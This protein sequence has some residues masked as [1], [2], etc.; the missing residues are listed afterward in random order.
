[1]HAWASG[2][3][4]PFFQLRELA[5]GELVHCTYSPKL[6][7][8][9][10]R[11]HESLERTVAHAYGRIRWDRT[12]NHILDMVVEDIDLTQPLTDMDFHRLFGSMPEFTGEMTTAEYIDWIRGS[13]E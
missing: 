12:K 3:E 1:M 13:G 6:H 10:L 2:A 11:A 9:I 8:K 5:T 4:P 7:G